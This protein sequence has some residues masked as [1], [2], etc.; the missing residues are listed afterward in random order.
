MLT[1]VVMLR[2]TQ[3]FGLD[4]LFGAFAVEHL[5]AQNASQRNQEAITSKLDAIGFGFVVPFFFVVSGVKL[6]IIALVHDPAAFG[7]I[8]AFPLLF[9]LLPL[10]ALKALGGAGGY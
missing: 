3:S 7:F 9:L 8:P 2:I 1:I 10:A 4:V 6:D 5:A